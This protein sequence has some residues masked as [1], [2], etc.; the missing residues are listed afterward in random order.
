MTV[1]HFWHGDGFD[2]G[3]GHGHGF[4]DG[5]GHGHGHGFGDGHGPQAMLV[6]SET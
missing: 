6:G 1:A 3:H 4:D 2:D 5:H